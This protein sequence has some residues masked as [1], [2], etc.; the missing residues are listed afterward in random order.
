MHTFTLL[1]SQVRSRGKHPFTDDKL[2][3]T[4]E[5]FFQLARE[6]GFDSRCAPLRWYDGK[7]ITQYWEYTKE[8][9]QVQKK[10]YTP[11]IV[12]DKTSFSYQD[13]SKKE[14]LHAKAIVVNPWELDMLASDKLLTAAA[15]ADISPKTILVSRQEDLH[16]AIKQLE[17][18]TVVLKPRTA[19]G[20]EGIQILSKAKARKIEFVQPMIVQEHIDSSKGIPK[21]YKGIHDYRIIYA[22]EKPIMTYIRIPA[23]GTVL[24]NF[25]QGATAKFIPVK[26]IP[27]KLEPLIQAILERLRVFPNKIFSM[28]FFFGENGK[29]RLIELNTKPTM[30]LYYKEYRTHEDRLHKSYLKYLATLV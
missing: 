27:K 6:Y 10:S 24:C 12:L 4:Y 22:G 28:D 5:R 21:L 26:N 19:S 15:F 2:A 13:I 3:D 1:Y 23:K 17:T 20:G 29:P 30:T 25:A 11:E 14:Q 8:G 16:A 7:K 18:K 9:W